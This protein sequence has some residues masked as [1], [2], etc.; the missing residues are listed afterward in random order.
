MQAKQRIFLAVVH[1]SMLAV[2]LLGSGSLIAQEVTKPRVYISDS[3]SW[4]TSGGFGGSGGGFGGISSGGARPQ[5]AEIIK[6]FNEKCSSCTVTAN[7]DKAD[8]AVILE[9]EG[10]K[11]PFSRDN[12]FA[13][14]NKD[15][16][17]IKSGSTRSLGNAVKEVCR[18][19]LNYWRAAASRKEP[20]STTLE[21]SGP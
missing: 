6:T 13:L 21:K 15:G 3:Q 9:H 11:D 12:K 5:T 8:Y 2:L 7:K 1:S 4:Q 16:D 14:F 20:S 10:G 18:V 17:V 19:I